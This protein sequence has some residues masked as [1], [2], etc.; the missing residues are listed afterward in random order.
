[1]AV[2]INIYGDPSVIEAKVTKALRD[3]ARRNGR[4]AVLG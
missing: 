3:Y 4:S 1:M 2:Q